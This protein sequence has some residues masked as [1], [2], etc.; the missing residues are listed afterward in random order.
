V[1]HGLGAF[2]HDGAE[3]VRTPGG[4]YNGNLVRHQATSSCTESQ[5]WY[6]DRRMRRLPF[7][8]VM[9]LGA[10]C[11]ARHS[12]NVR[13]LMPRS[14]QISAIVS[15]SRCLMLRALSTLVT[16]TTRRIDAG[17]VIWHR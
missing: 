11:F 9:H 4:Q 10:L 16:V 7:G 5:R 8:S 15:F 6:S 14:A 3:L 2:F 12:Q 13:R 17:S 1:V